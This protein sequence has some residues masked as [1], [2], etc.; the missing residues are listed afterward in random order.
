MARNDFQERTKLLI[1]QVGTGDL[2]AGC[3]VDQPYAQDQHETL[4]YRHI[5]GGGPR[6]LGGPLLA[7][8]E[9]TIAELAKHVI[10]KEGSAI[11]RAMISFART[12]AYDYVEKNAPRKTG[13]LELSGEPWVKDGNHEVFREPSR[14][15]RQPDA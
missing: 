7:N 12:M 13:H 6:Y 8:A 14:V 11:T 15:P 3:L 2:V 9:E 4:T 10:T 5:H 1:D